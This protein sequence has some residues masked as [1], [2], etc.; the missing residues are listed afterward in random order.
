MGFGNRTDGSN[1]NA[2]RAALRFYAS[3][4]HRKDLEKGQRKEGEKKKRKKKGRRKK[5]KKKQSHLKIFSFGETFGRFHNP[6]SVLDVEVINL[7]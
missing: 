5:Q 1:R 3:D 6:V 2:F 7:K 4:F